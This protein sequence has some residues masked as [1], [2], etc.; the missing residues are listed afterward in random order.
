M[1]LPTFKLSR[2]KGELAIRVVHLPACSG[3]L[4]LSRL[5]YVKIPPILRNNKGVGKMKDGRIIA[6]SLGLVIIRI[7]LGLTFLAHGSQKLF[8]LFGG[9]GIA[10]FAGL[11]DTMNLDFGNAV[12]MAYLVGWTEF[13]GGLLIFFGLLTRIAA[14]GIGAIMVVAIGAVHWSYGFFAQDNGIEY[15]LMILAIA[16]GLAFAGPGIYALDTA[17][18]L[19]YMKPKE[20]VPKVEIGV[21]EV[22]QSPPSAP[23]KPAEAPSEPST[24]T[25]S[26]EEGGTGT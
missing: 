1:R 7:V 26:T 6:M 5:Q 4:L 25:S 19:K 9:G 23:T 13:L 24:E 20:P 14:L 15:P 22:T 18:T 2:P 21:P 8:G 12:L 10:G 3:L 17:F 11:L 16:L